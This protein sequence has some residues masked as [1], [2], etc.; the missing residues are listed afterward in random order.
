MKLTRYL[1]PLLALAC[2]IPATAS[3]QDV[4]ADIPVTTSWTD[5]VASYPS[6]AGN[7]SYV[8]NKGADTIVVSCLTSGT[9][10][11]SGGNLINPRDEQFCNSAHIWVRSLNTPTIVS[12]GI[13][14]TASGASSGSNA[15]AGTTGAAVPGQASYTAFS[16]SGVLTGVS[17]SNPLPVTGSFSAAVPSTI[18]SGQQTLTTSAAALP[19]NTLQ[20][21]A[22]LLAL[23]TNT[24]TVY[25]GPSGVTISTGTPLTAGQ[26]VSLAISNTSA[27]YIIGTNTTDK[28]AFTGN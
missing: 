28:V 24:G 4:G 15:A 11:A 18:I 17:S 12:A 13:Q 22:T 8:Q 27:I 20:N 25:F 19:S 9:A 5:I 2:S 16:N 21:G 23:P 6:L 3:A 14:A 10:P 7:F 1:A 26:S